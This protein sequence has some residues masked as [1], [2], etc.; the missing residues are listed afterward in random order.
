MV[1]VVLFVVAWYVS[2]FIVFAVSILLCIIIISSFDFIISNICLG[3]YSFYFEFRVCCVLS[4][5]IIC[6][7]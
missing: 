5:H 4:L 7:C 2:C 1:H 3:W 6:M